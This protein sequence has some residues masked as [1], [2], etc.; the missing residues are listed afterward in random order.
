VHSEK[1]SVDCELPL[2]QSTRLC[3]RSNLV[4]DGNRP[5]DGFI[6]DSPTFVHL[7]LSAIGSKCGSIT[8]LTI[9]PTKIHVSMLG[10]RSRQYVSC[11]LFVFAIFDDWFSSTSHIPTAFPGR[12]AEAEGEKT[13]R[14]RKSLYELQLVLL[15][16][17]E[18]SSLA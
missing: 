10:I 11:F 12:E 7:V 13:R 4:K 1:K 9:E 15:C 3:Y 14:G 17:K 6:W 5:V 16:I 18:W 2:V 8:R